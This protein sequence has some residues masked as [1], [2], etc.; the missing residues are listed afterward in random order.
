MSS[1]PEF[2][3]IG[4]QQLGEIHKYRGSLFRLSLDLCGDISLPTPGHCF[5]AYRANFLINHAK[6]A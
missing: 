6:E 3:L 5:L 2:R 4:S 1:F